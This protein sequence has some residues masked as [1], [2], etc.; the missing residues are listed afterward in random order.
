MSPHDPE[1]DPPAANLP[2]PALPSLPP[3]AAPPRRLL[4]V[5]RDCMRT[6]RLSLRTEKLYLMWIRHY[7][8]FHAGRHPRE[9]GAHELEN[10]LTHLAVDRGVSASTQNQALAAVIFLYRHVLELDPPWVSNVTRA[11]RRVRLPV[12][13]TRDEV[14][15]VLAALPR[16]YALIGHLL[17]GT[18]M[19][20]NE[21]LG[22]RV[23]DLEFARGEIIVRGGKG[24]KD[25]I[26]VM[27]RSLIEPLRQHLH[28]LYAWYSQQREARAP[29]VWV[30]EALARKYPR[31][32]FQWGW[33]FVFP[34][35]SLTTD[36]R[37]GE[38]LRYHLHEKG[39]QRAMQ[40]AVRVA[41]IT[42]PASCHTL[43]HSFATHLIESG[44]DIRTV[45]ELLGHSDVKTTMIY[46]HV[47]NRG[48][49]GV[50]SPADV[51]STA[52]PS[53]LERDRR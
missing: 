13:L 22:M 21:C 46:T 38:I 34:A 32:P 1:P 2:Q 12:V 11:R 9:L 51:L 20:V 3:A 47:L 35:R 16:D 33:Q 40:H 30:P 41:R 29:G 48:G 5:M 28:A 6:R 31:S 39:L 14:R 8:R 26:T 4:D 53:L 17:Y 52:V 7:I 19:R 44:Y 49:R 27:P 15:A 23:K 45:Q 18:G 36:P 24:D 43:R 10:F 42:K 25:R 37:T 50:L